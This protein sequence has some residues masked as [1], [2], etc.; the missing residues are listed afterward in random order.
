MTLQEGD[1]PEAKADGENLVI[2]GQTVS[3]DG[4]ALKFEK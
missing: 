2:G 3:Y 1:A 4:K